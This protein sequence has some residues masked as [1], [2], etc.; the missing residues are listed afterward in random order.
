MKLVQIKSCN[1][2]QWA[3]YN[4]TDELISPWF[5]SQDEALDWL[6]LNETSTT[7]YS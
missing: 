5:T 3:W 2:Y 7:K 4:E 1:K 6:E